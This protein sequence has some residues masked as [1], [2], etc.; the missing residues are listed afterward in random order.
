MKK[1][2]ALGKIEAAKYFYIEFL[3][4][5]NNPLT[6]KVNRKTLKNLVARFNPEDTIN[7]YTVYITKDFQASVFFVITINY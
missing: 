6:I 5:E 3:I 7:M 2:I 4:R 1:D